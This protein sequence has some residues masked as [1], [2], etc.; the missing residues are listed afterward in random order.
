MTLQWKATAPSY[1]VNYT[2][3]ECLTSRF[4]QT[5]GVI[6]RSTSNQ[7]YRFPKSAT[8]SDVYCGTPSAVCEETFEGGSE[9]YRYSDDGN[10]QGAVYN[11]ASCS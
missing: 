10:P 3:K 8:P 1:Q 9:G 5:T 7:L 6:L 2:L 11:E 4:K